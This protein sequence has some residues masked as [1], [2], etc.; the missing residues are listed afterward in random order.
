MKARIIFLVLSAAILFAAFSLYD[1]AEPAG[2][3][4]PGDAG[5]AVTIAVATDLHYLAPELTDNGEFFTRLVTD[6][7]GKVMLYID[8]LVRAFAFQIAEEKPDALI[9][10]G[11]LT[12]NGETVSHEALARI[13]SEIEA[14]GVP[15][16]VMPGNHDMNSSMAARFS[17]DGYEFVASPTEGEFADIYADFGFDEALSRDES[18]LS[19]TAQL[20]PGLRLLMLDVN[21]RTNPGWVLDGTLEWLEAQLAEAEAAGERVLAVSHQNIFAHNSF[22]TSGYVI[23]NGGS[24]LSLYREYGVLCNLS[25]HIHLQHTAEYEGFHEIVTSSLAVS[26]NQYGVLTVG[27]GACSYETV[28]T[29]VSSWAAA[30][31]ITD[32]NLLDFA[33]YSS[34]FFRGTAVSQALEQLSGVKNAESLAEFYADV[35]ANYFAGRCDL[36]EWDD[37]LLDEWDSHGFFIPMYLKTIRADGAADH[38]KLS[39]QL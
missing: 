38:T 16:Y 17:G 12:F 33:A 32:E 13:L 23:G 19:Y 37:A 7:D 31:G 9:L 34:R 10:S 25:G 11:D 26:P 1:A 28:E 18:S 39:W 35:N 14:A 27:N 8:E 15:V 22:F 21:T 3:T 24:L 4:E 6:A 2:P 20:A 5:D 30:E 36:I 29:D